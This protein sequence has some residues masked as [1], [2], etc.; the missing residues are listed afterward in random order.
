MKFMKCL[1]TACLIMTFSV[2]AYASQ[3]T[4]SVDIPEHTSLNEDRYQ[5]SVD[6][7]DNQGFA[8]LQIELGYNDGVLSCEKVVPGEVVKGML[9][10]SNPSASGDKTS[11]ILSVAGFQNTVLD[12]NLA[13]FVFEKPKTGN[14]EIEFVLVELMTEDGQKVAYKTRI[15]NNYG[16]FETA[17]PKEEN[18]ASKPGGG[19]G[20]SGDAV[21]QKPEKPEQAEQPVI[22]EEPENVLV[23]TFSDVTTA[24][25]AKS[26]IE[27]AVSM[28]LVKGM[29][30]GT[31]APDKAMTRAEFATILWNVAGRPEAGEMTRFVDVKAGEWYT[32]QIAWAS[33]AGYIT[34]ISETEFSP[35]GLIT[36]EQAMA[37]LYRYAGR[38][39]TT[40]T[41]GDFKDK[42]DIYDYA[43]PAMGWAVENNIISGVGDGEIAPKMSATRAQL[44]TIMVRFLNS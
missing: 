28:G 4:V 8:S 19:G 32:K 41:L 18:P 24:H 17:P 25:W 36:R 7:K 3:T 15:D 6:I 9:T 40:E 2:P 34:G 31:F 12:G 16:E 33:Q 23:V 35:N 20:S 13:T 37:I 44:A 22:Q 38:P 42:S 29:P 10:D 39:A 11:A 30:D 21:S 27:K 14:P 43:L 1:T 5:I 26:Y